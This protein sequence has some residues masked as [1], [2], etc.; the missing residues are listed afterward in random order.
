[1]PKKMSTTVCFIFYNL[2]FAQKGSQ[3]MTMLDEQMDRTNLF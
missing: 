1:M 3:M 2:Y